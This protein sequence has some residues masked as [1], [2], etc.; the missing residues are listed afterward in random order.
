V[1]SLSPSS[2]R[3]VRPSHS[4]YLPRDTL[5]TSCRSLHS[6]A[7]A[8]LPFPF[9]HHSPSPT[10]ITPTS[11][12]TIDSTNPTAIGTFSPLAQHLQL[13]EAPAC[14]YQ[15]G[16]HPSLQPAGRDTEK[17]REREREREGLASTPFDALDPVACPSSSSAHQ[18]SSSLTLVILFLARLSPTSRLPSTLI[19]TRL[20]ITSHPAQSAAHPAP[21]SSLRR[22]SYISIGADRRPL[23]CLDLLL[24]VLFTDQR[25]RSL[26]SLQLSH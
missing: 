8:A 24:C 15:P 11:S 17:E 10:Y 21:D 22:A 19:T 9:P 20:H 23:P 7:P 3:L 16:R 26:C 13:S 14:N 5:T 2:S 6:F 4:P 25:M 12:I 1:R 18:L